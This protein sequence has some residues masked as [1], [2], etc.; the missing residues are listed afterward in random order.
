MARLLLWLCS[1]AAATALAGAGE[2]GLENEAPWAAVFATTAAPPAATSSSESSQL[3]NFLPRHG[4]SRL[5]AFL[6]AIFGRIR[7]SFTGDQEQASVEDELAVQE[8]EVE[9]IH[10]RRLQPG[11][12]WPCRPSRRPGEYGVVLGIPP[13][14][15]LVCINVTS[16]EVFGVNHRIVDISFGKFGGLEVLML[17][18]FRGPVQYIE[19]IT[20][21]DYGH[22][23]VNK[24]PLKTFRDHSCLNREQWCFVSQV[25]PIDSGFL[26]VDRHRVIHYNYTWLVEGN[27]AAS[28]ITETYVNHFGQMNTDELNMDEDAKLNFPTNVAEYNPHNMTHVSIDA[29]QVTGVPGVPGA[30]VFEI[31]PLIPDAWCRLIFVTDTGNHRVVMLNASAI[32]QFDYVGQ[33]GL[34]GEARANSTGFN[35]PWGIAVS[36]PAWEGRYEPVYAH[37]FVVDRKN[38]RLVK[39]NLGYPLMP[40]EFDVPS[41]T[42]PLV[43]DAGEAKWMCRRYDKPRLAYSAEYGQSP[44]VFDRPKGLTDP[45]AVAIYRHFI[46]VAEVGGNA[47]T[48][49]RVDHQPPYGL[50]YVTYFKPVQGVYMQGGMAMSPFGYVWFNYI[51]ADMK[52]TFSSMFLPEILVECIAPNRF[53]EFLEAC[54]NRTWYQDLLQDKQRYLDHVSFIMNASAIN[55]IHKDRPNYTDIFIF[56]NSNDFDIDLLNQMVYNFTMVECEE[57]TTPTPPPFFGGNEDG[58]VIEGKSQSEFTRR[59]GA[60]RW[61]PVGVALI[62]CCISMFLA[63]LL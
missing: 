58:W 9:V 30:D 46:V 61:S 43:Y 32:G 7:R 19:V 63:A 55:W 56:N 14:R 23:A 29:P 54:V 42:Q 59:S 5:S 24:V 37:V 25:Q 1:L 10:E 21:G 13:E 27:T 36:S 57:P 3:L 31:T 26:V 8:A 40:C 62:T 50:K 47:I 4:R 6:K 51:G 18:Q 44:D 20:S 17:S 2:P 34:T 52:N 48:L 12:A 35:W 16:Q 22:Y 11:T 45:T 49:L 41:Q 15:I 60:H 53:T 39:L 38:H 33:F 28:E